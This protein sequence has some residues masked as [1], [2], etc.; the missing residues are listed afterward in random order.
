[1]KNT[2]VLCQDVWV[3]KELVPTAEEREA[4]LTELKNVSSSSE[5]AYGRA[6]TLLSGPNI[7]HDQN[8]FTNLVPCLRCNL[9]TLDA[10]APQCLACETALCNK[11]RNE[12]YPYNARWHL[13]DTRCI[14]RVLTRSSSWW[15]H[16]SQ[17][18]QIF[19][20]YA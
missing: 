6:A 9:N 18:H 11:C 10:L 4:A 14:K 5:D 7:P 12:I 15:K 3:P 19:P 17:P 2:Q 20:C 13:D 16:R 1:M 8:E